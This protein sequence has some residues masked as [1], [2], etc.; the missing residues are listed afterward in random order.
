MFE[1]KTYVICCAWTSTA[2]DDFGNVTIGTRDI[3]AKTE[4]QAVDELKRDL[5]GRLVGILEI[6]KWR[7]SKEV[8]IMSS[9][10]RLKFFVKGMNESK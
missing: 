7:K 9:V 5:D 2:E 1:M 6:T 3:I 8:Q 4:R 10:S